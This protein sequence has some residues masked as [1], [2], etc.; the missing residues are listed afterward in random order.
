[1]VQYNLKT[2]T[3]TTGLISL[4]S[5]TRSIITANR[6]SKTIFDMDIYSSES[7]P[8]TPF[9]FSRAFKYFVGLYFPIL[10]T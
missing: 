10:V 2:K 5:L 6:L 7:F 9:N 3:E 4:Q 8:A 1:M